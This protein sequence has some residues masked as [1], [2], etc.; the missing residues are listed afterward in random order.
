MI[1][2][3][4]I[5]YFCQIQTLNLIETPETKQIIL[6]KMLNYRKSIV[7]QKKCVVKLKEGSKHQIQ[8]NFYNINFD[9]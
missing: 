9:L 7:R 4:E 8:R 2:F 1:K 5:G 6:K 3:A